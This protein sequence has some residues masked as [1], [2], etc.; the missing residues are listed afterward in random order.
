MLVYKLL[1]QL[2]KTPLW[3]RIVLAVAWYGFIWTLTEWP[4]ATPDNT[5]QVIGQAGGSYETTEGA[6]FAF[7]TSSHFFVFG[8]QAVLLL[9]MLDPRLRKNVRLICVVLLCTIS[10]GIVDEFHQSFV[11]GRQPRALDVLKDGI[12]ALLFLWLVL[13]VKVFMSKQYYTAN[14]IKAEE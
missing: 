14:P 8:V 9:F 7:R 3:I 4:Q 2:G 5:M 1:N 12:G 11:P 13:R 10:L 6:N